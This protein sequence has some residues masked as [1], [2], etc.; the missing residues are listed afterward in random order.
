MK[1]KDFVDKMERIANGMEGKTR[2]ELQSELFNLLWEEL[3]DSR[4]LFMEWVRTMENPAYIEFLKRS[5]GISILPKKENEKEF[6]YDLF[7]KYFKD[8]TLSEKLNRFMMFAY[9]SAYIHHGG[10]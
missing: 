3:E 1:E 2:H 9:L 8:V 7:F 10:E 4:P 6:F 5:C